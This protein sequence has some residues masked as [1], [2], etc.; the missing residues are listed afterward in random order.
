[1]LLS[2]VV[3]GLGL[4]AFS[5]SSNYLLSLAIMVVVGLGEAGR[6]VLN[7]VLLHT[8]VEDAY[9]GRVASVFMM[10]VGTMALGAFVVGLIAEF[11]GPQVGLGSFSLL[12]VVL[13]LVVYAFVPR[14]RDL[15]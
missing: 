6:Q 10:Q 12:L 9:R 14:L 4:T 15:E 5:A 13:A 3:A 8:H 2:V 11:V 1:M 7:N